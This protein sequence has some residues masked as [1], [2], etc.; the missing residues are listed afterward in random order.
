MVQSIFDDSFG[1][2]MAAT[3]LHYPP[4]RKQDV[5][6]DYHGTPVA[7]PYRWLEDDN[8]EE[9]K[10][11]VE[12]QNAVTFAYLD[13]I[14]EREGI[15]D[16][17]T[18]L[19]DY[20]RYSAPFKRGKRYFYS[21]NSGLQNQ[22]V[23]YVTEDP[24]AQGRV[25]LDPN[26]LSDD[27]TVSLSGVSIT[28]DGRFMAY[29]L[30]ESGSDWT[31]WK[32]RDI[33]SGK[34]LPDEVRWSKFSGAAW[35]KD[36][37]GFYYSAYDAPEEGAAFTGQNL[38]QKLYF[39]R[40]GTPQ[41][42]D[43]LIY[44]RPDH[45]TWGFAADV[46]ED[47]RWLVI[48]QWEGTE[49]KNRLFLQD[50][51]SPG[52]TVEPFLDAFDAQYNVVENDGATFLVHT[53]F[54]A[55]R[56]R[57]VTIHREHPSSAHWKILIPEDP[58]TSVLSSVVAAGRRLVAQWMTDAHEQLKVYDWSGVFERDIA[59]PTLGTAGFSGRRHDLEGFYSFTSF[60]YP[61]TIYRYDLSS[62][63][64]SVFRAPT[65]DFQPSDFVTEQVFYPSKDGTRI[66]MF[67]TC[68]KGLRR[69]G[70]NPTLLYGYGGFDVSLTPAYSTG[71]LVWMEMG[72]VYAQANL[73][74]G[75][76]Y[77]QAWHDAGRLK[78]KQN[79]FDD[80]IAGAE[81]LISERLTSSSKLAIQ[82]GS[83]GGLLVGACMTQ[84]PDLFGA[85]LP[86]VGVL[87]MLRFHLFTIGWAWKS[88]Y[89]SSET[90]D[91]FETLYRYSPLH[92]LRPGVAYPPT[93]VATGDHDDRVVPAHSHKFIATLQ[94]C[95]A[96]PA[97]VL[98]RIETKA[99][100][101]AGKPTDKIIAELADEWAF[102]VK[103]LDMALPETSGA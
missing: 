54:G 102:L 28:D 31:T 9:T 83:N 21:Y 1:D 88:D 91:G 4:T 81:W 98:T 6:E 24:A 67:L 100:H 84:R 89:G 92:N 79:V 56:K 97:P 50:L 70:E 34:D 29:G 37:S 38:N 60:T 85:C 32:V 12:A 69:D 3:P 82:G 48:S 55:P 80:F 75:G 14:P 23:L 27:G 19:M 40:L 51:T 15:R 25:L 53:D 93:L 33:D 42:Q 94:A 43:A 47:G 71:R 17:L 10:A 101:G 18:A 8:S 22:S 49:R 26:G 30:S 46:T 72:G 41:S 76:E 87:D 63:V 57:L 66:P 78:Q 2:A 39:H 86:A 62:G 61:T 35:R 7:D 59:L 90:R 103:N 36:G 74:G 5:V 73:R 96:G 20:E 11:W 77:G 68:R 13:E 52:S 58:G 99:G 45:P 64:S 16:R 95:Q 44:A 65:V